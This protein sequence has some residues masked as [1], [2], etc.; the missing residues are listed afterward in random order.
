MRKAG[1]ASRVAPITLLLGLSSPYVAHGQ[2]DYS[3][4]ASEVTPPPGAECCRSPFALRE[5]RALF[6]LRDPD[7]VPAGLRWS[8]DEA[9]HPLDI[10]IVE[11]LEPRLPPELAAAQNRLQTL[12]PFATVIMHEHLGV[13]LCKRR[14]GAALPFRPTI[15]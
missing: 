12:L 5:T 7:P 3:L 15:V 6:P 8:V 11:F 1:S 10:E 4:S 13:E 9:A 14:E 2:S